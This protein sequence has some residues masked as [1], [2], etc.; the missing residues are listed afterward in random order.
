M[1]KLRQIGNSWG[2]IIPKSILDLLKIKPSVDDIEFSVE[3]E[4]LKIQKAKK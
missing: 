1:K 3:G 2:V 4:I